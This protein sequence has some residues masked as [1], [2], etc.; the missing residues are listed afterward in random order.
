MGKLEDQIKEVEK[1]T[2][3][4]YKITIVPPNSEQPGTYQTTFEGV[5]KVLIKEGDGIQKIAK[6]FGVFK[7]VNGDTFY[8]SISES[9]EIIKAD[10]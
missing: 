8:F 5:G 6:A 3:K 9:L 1:H 7:A 4:H 2:G 10:N